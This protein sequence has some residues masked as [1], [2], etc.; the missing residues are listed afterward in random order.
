MDCVLRYTRQTMSGRSLI[1]FCKHSGWVVNL[2]LKKVYG[3]ATR[4]WQLQVSMCWPS[5]Q[6]HFEQPDAS[7]Q[8]AATYLN[9]WAK[10]RRKNPILFILL[11]SY[12]S[13]H[14]LFPFTVYKAQGVKYVSLIL[15]LIIAIKTKHLKMWQKVQYFSKERWVLLNLHLSGTVKCL[16]MTFCGPESKAGQQQS[17][18]VPYEQPAARHAVLR[19]QHH[20][21]IWPAPPHTI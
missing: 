5:F 15:V 16:Y 18:M 3:K 8:K 1:A 4:G 13:Q 7:Y 11:W 12:F 17:D 6:Q 2:E 21:Q 10:R 9:H 19:L 14:H 20:W